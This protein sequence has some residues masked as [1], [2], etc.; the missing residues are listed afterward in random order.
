M[1]TLALSNET[2]E[3]DGDSDSQTSP[4]DVCVMTDVR[5][6]ENPGCYEGGRCSEKYSEVLQAH[7]WFLVSDLHERSFFIE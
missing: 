6:K 3:D 4:A 5:T 1:K 7:L 2:A